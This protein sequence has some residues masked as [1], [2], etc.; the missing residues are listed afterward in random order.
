MFRPGA[1]ASHLLVPHAKYLVDA[2]GID[3]GFAATLACSGVTTYSAIRKLPAAHR[4]RLGRRAR[5]RRV[6][7]IALSILRALGIERVI[8]C[9]IDDGKLAAAR[10][11]G[12]ARR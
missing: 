7:M 10:D 8:A 3:E 1:Y 5:L 11:A 6:G 4:P 9:D 12:A 2:S